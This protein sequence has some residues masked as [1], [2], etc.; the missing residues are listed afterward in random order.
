MRLKD[1]EQAWLA[2]L[3]EPARE[4]Q[5]R[6]PGARAVRH[7]LSGEELAL[8]VH[9]VRRQRY[10]TL[11]AHLPER[12]RLLLG[13]SHAQALLADF[14]ERGNLPPLFPPH[15][16]LTELLA[17]C[18]EYLNR[19]QLVIP[20][21]R[22][23]IGYEMTAAHLAFFSLPR[24]LPPTPGPQLAAWAAVL[25]L[26]PHFPAVLESLNHGQEPVELPE[27]PRTPF[28]ISREFRGLRLEAV[29]PLVGACL[30]ACDGLKSWSK[31]AA[32]AGERR[33]QPPAAGESDLL[34]SWYEHLLQ[35]GVLLQSTGS[36]GL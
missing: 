29:P 21:L 30:E 28:L 14:L 22:D 3:L 19:Q 4:D 15:K 5:V 6:S 8:R 20:H 16:L 1:F 17:Y 7:L 34:Q 18:T 26:G 12:V 32:A 27:A 24:P 2:L 10:Q 36:E 25:R 33:Q 11:E 9:Q 31:L 13:Y 23:L 35:R